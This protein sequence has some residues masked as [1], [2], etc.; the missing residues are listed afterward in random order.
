[1]EAPRKTPA[2]ATAEVLVCGGG[3]AGMIAA[4]AA[5]RNGA[6]TLLVE[7][8]GFLG[9]VFTSGLLTTIKGF[10]PDQGSG[11]GCWKDFS[12][13]VVRGIPLE[14]LERLNDEKAAYGDI[15]DPVAVKH[16]FDDFVLESKVRT[17]LHSTVVDA[18]VKDGAL[19]GIIVENRSGR[20]AIL[21]GVVV[22]ATGDAAVASRSSVPC[23]KGRPGDGA[24]QPMT[25]CFVVADAKYPWDERCRSIE[26]SKRA[27][28]V[29]GG[30]IPAMSKA[31]KNRELPPSCL[32]AVPNATGGRLRK[33]QI[34]INAI[35]QYGDA[36]D[37]WVMTQAEIE[38][39]RKVRQLFEFFRRQPGYEDSYLANTGAQIGIRETRRIQGEYVL[40]E[41]DIINS[42]R[43]EDSIA[44]G[45]WQIDIHSP[46]GGKTPGRWEPP[47]KPGQ[48]YE[49]PYRCL[50]PVGVEGLLVAGRCISATHAAHS[51]TRVAATCMALGHAAGTAAALSVKNNTAPRRLRTKELQNLL[52]DQGAAIH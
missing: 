33:D 50:V 32:C 35:W 24:I 43:F 9:G 17:L 20:G 25:P 10:G 8:Y 34:W 21:A 5:A 14:L 46:D 15:I 41:D 48:T 44:K 28:L 4:V 40:N 22:D 18:C 39:R 16:V 47:K 27:E 45:C 36:T 12:E 7:H 3:P 51:S 49:I 26:Q 42:R 2:I 30:V 19:K 38:G 11:P 52:Q 23:L 13:P 29:H 37:A 1:M 6:Q 31:M